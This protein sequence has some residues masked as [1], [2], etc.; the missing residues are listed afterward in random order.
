MDYLIRQ[1]K[2]GRRNR[3]PEGL[4]SLEVEDQLKP[5]GLLH[6]Q[7]GGL[8]SLLDLV[9]IGGGAPKQV[10]KARPIGHEPPSS[11]KSRISYIAGSRFV[12]AKSKM[13]WFNENGHLDK[14]DRIG[15]GGVPPW[16]SNDATMAMNSSERPSGW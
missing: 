1:D 11:T 16:Q 4:G 2:E 8:G 7:V 5:H 10:D 15:K 3:D 14:G 9:H 12:A 6:G 13:L